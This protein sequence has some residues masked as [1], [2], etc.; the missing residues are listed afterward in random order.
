LINMTFESV[1]VVVVIPTSTPAHRPPEPQHEEIE[2]ELDLTPDAAPH[3]QASQSESQKR[4]LPPNR[5]PISQRSFF[6]QTIFV[7]TVAS[8]QVLCEAQVG[9]LLVSLEDIGLQ[10]GT[11]DERELSW[12][13]AAYGWVTNRHRT[14]TIQSWR[15][16]ECV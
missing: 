9:M 16:A 3:T 1:P 2:L 5:R 15:D 6:M 13:P 7:A 12:F 10:V 14:P 4:N 11:H 8:P